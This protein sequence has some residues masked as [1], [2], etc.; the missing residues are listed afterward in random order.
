MIL[1]T[2]IRSILSIL[3]LQILAKIAGPKQISQCTFYDYIVGITIGSIAAVMAIDDQIE[4]YICAVAMI[5]YVLIS[6]LFSWLTTK[7]I[8]AREHLTGT[9]HILIFHGKII[10]DN[11]KKV[12]FDINDL[13]TQC[14]SAGYFDLSK[15]QFAIMETTGQV[16]F[17]LNTED[18]PITKKDMNKQCIQEELM[19]HVIM[20]GKIMKQNL[21]TIGKNENWLHTQLEKE[22]LCIDDV[23]LAIANHNNDIYFYKKNEILHQNHYFL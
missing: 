19:A 12:H 17:L 22:K 13:L 3:L 18:E 16:S 14:R 10:E 9:P 21:K 1:S 7:S 11:L 20:D 8:K 6:L 15:I 2:I 5:V 4:W 23:L